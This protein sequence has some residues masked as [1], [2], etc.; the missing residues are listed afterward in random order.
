MHKTYSQ[1][2]SEVTRKWIVLDAAEAPLGRLATVAAKYLIGKYK[3]TYTPHIDG[4]DYVI[5]VNAANLVVTGEKAADKTYYRY[6]GFPG[7]LTETTLRAQLAKDPT[8]IIDAAI[9]GM[10]PKNKLQSERMKRLKVYAGEAHNH[11]AQKPV[12][13]GVK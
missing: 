10:L 4:G 13:M 5:I 1:K 2:P 8:K 7:G 12:K 11:E 9:K 3:P 6:S